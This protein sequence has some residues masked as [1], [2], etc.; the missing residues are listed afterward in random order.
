MI[1]GEGKF[2]DGRSPVAQPVAIAA[3]VDAQHLELRVASQADVTRAT[4]PIRLVEFRDIKLDAPI[5]RGFWALR[6]PDGGV[7]EC[8]PDFYEPLAGVI[9]PSVGAR[10]SRWAERS[11]KIAGACFLLSVAILVLF[12]QFG[13][14]FLAKRAAAVVPSEVE[15]V[16]TKETMRILDKIYFD[17]SEMDA[18][19]QEAIREGFA[20]LVALNPGAPEYEILFRRSKIGPNAFALPAGKIIMTDEL[21]DF[22]DNDEQIYG[23]LAHELGHIHYNH[24]L[25]AA[26]QATGHAVVITVFLGD[27]TSALSVAAALPSVLFEKGHS[28]RHEREADTYATLFSMQAGMEP[29][30]LIDALEKLTRRYGDG[31][32]MAILSTHPP[33][34]ERAELIRSVA[35]D[36]R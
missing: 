17:P 20:A 8:P 19:R 30:H 34:A 27:V 14:P 21:V 5:G 35:E 15:Q 28:R 11:L 29:H 16:I 7:V 32:R 1:I 36:A 25:Q 13:I 6:L 26:L 10:F 22:L 31:S 3:N 18:E 23:V 4:D 24:G 33:T 9:R 12:F 2:Y